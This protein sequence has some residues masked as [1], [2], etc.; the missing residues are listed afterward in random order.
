MEEMNE[1][2]QDQ[3]KV[4]K[5]KRT[6][7]PKVEQKNDTPFGFGIDNEC[8]VVVKCQYSQRREMAERLFTVHREANGLTLRVPACGTSICYQG[9]DRIPLGWNVCGCGKH[10]FIKWEEA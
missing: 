7:K 6:R 10:S 3:Q 9:A 4:T 5:K 2:T 8:A 1:E